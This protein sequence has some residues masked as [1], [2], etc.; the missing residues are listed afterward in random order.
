M[1]VWTTA[2]LV[3]LPLLVSAAGAAAQPFALEPVWAERPSRAFPYIHLYMCRNQLVRFFPNTIDRLEREIETASTM[4]FVDGGAHVRLYYRGSLPATDAACADVPDL[5]RPR[6][7]GTPPPGPK[8][9][10]SAVVITAAS[11]QINRSPLAIT[12]QPVRTDL[13]TA[14]PA[15]PLARPAITGARIV[16]AAGDACSGPIAQPYPWPETATAPPAYDYRSVLMWAMGQALGLPNELASPSVRRLPS[17]GALSRDLTSS[18][19]QALRA[20]YGP[21]QSR[22]YWA[23]STDGVTWQARGNTALVPSP[24]LGLSVCALGGSFGPTA[25]KRFLVASTDVSGM[26]DTVTVMLADENLASG[27]NRQSLGATNHP[28]RVAC[29]DHSVML[30]FID[31]SG[32]LQLRRSTDGLVW[33]SV[34]LPP[35]PTS[36]NVPPGIEFVRWKGWYYMVLAGQRAGLTFLLSTDDGASF[37]IVRNASTWGSEF[38]PL[39]FC[40]ESLASCGVLVPSVP[41]N[42]FQPYDRF[43]ATGIANPGGGYFG[44]GDYRELLGGQ[45]GR[46]GL[47]PQQTLAAY[48]NLRT[49][50]R[51]TSPV[52]YEAGRV[53]TT[54]VG[55]VGGLPVIA[56]QDRDARLITDSVP[57]MTWDSARN[58]WVL[59]ATY[60]RAYNTDFVLV[61]VPPPG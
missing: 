16:L 17:P 31:P 12:C 59:L 57:A 25:S 56:L 55:E 48:F 20:V 1:R 58:R 41:G 13:W 30:A 2:A 18:D 50:P 28:P 45:V 7:V 4:W 36:T 8:P 40:V 60:L 5:Y 38:S 32:R 46:S 11:A 51:W 10:F 47:T 52:R 61:P 35:A 44:G 33:T 29:G 14:A 43:D 15:S 26:T 39:P 9:P 3:C 34:A 42:Y 49:T 22:A 27:L 54:A 19:R 24:S 21:I 23:T 53:L 37:H 6:L